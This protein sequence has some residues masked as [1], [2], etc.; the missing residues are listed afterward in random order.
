[1]P[2]LGSFQI[3]GERF[4]GATATLLVL[5]RDR[6]DGIPSEDFDDRS[7]IRGG[8]EH[9]RSRKHAAGGGAI[10]LLSFVPA[11]RHAY[12]SRS[13]IQRRIRPGRGPPLT[14]R[15][16]SPWRL[17]NIGSVCMGD[18]LQNALEPVART[19]RED[20]AER[21]KLLESRLQT[22]QGNTEDP[23]SLLR[24]VRLESASH[25]PPARPRRAQRR[26]S[27]DVVRVAFIQTPNRCVEA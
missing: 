7:R 5:Y 14:M 16:V 18:L 10:L 4:S 26:R 3:V 13:G 11:S 25:S 19:S 8:A 1:M 21:L 20:L 15:T 12:F 22:A 2:R 27:P 6:A 23:H 9:L 17:P 24:R